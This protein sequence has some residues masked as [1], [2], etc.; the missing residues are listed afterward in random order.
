[1]TVYRTFPDMTSLFADLMTREWIGLVQAVA[2]ADA[3]VADLPGAVAARMVSAVRALRANPLFHRIVEIDPELLL[4][5]LLQ[6]RGR[7]QQAVL[8]LLEATIAEGQLGG[9]L[10]AGDPALLARTILLASQGTVLSGLTMTDGD[11][12]EAQLDE[13]LALLIERYLAP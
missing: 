2:G 3:D 8:D 6:R 5:Y 11:V 10:R 1:M 9:G 4:P 7:S 13:Q 12:S